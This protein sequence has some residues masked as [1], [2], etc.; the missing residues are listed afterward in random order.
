[1]CAYAPNFRVR[2]FKNQDGALKGIVFFFLL[3]ETKVQTNDLAGLWGLSL[4][5]YPAG[6]LL[7]DSTPPFCSAS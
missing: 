7:I 2:S 4:S 5:V 3:P 1:M 6:S